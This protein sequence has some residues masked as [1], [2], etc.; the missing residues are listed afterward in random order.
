MTAVDIFRDTKEQFQRAIGLFD[1]VSQGFFE[2]LRI[3]VND[4]PAGRKG[5][6]PLLVQQQEH[7]LALLERRAHQLVTFFRERASPLT[8]EEKGK[9]ICADLH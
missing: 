8:E 7:S 2:G 3:A 5:R 1:D 4:L 9:L 6:R